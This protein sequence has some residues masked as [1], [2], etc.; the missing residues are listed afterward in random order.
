MKTYK[1]ILPQDNH[2]PE[3]NQLLPLLAFIFAIG[4]LAASFFQGYGLLLAFP[5]L[6]FSL[7]ALA[8][9]RG[10]VLS[11]IALCLSFISLIISITAILLI[12]YSTSVMK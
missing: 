8:E 12:Y 7:L 11:I 10:R 2:L 6:V 4:A 1:Y 5:G 3:G 9:N